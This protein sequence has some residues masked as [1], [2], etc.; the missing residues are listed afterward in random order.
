MRGLTERQSKV[1]TQTSII[2]A[3]RA[4]IGIRDTTGPKTMQSTIRKT[5][6]RKVESRVRAPEVFTLTIVWPIIAQPPIPPNRPV[7]MLA[8]PWPRDSRVLF[9]RV[10][11]I[12]S[13]SWAVIS[14]SI[15]PTRAKA[16][17][18]GAIRVRVAAVN[19]TSGR[20]GSGS[21]AG[22]LPLSPTV[23]TARWAPA[24][25]AVSATIDTSGAGTTVVN[26]GSSA[27]SARPP[28]SSG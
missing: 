25:T 7:T 22:S 8:T 14:D 3:T 17:A 2:T 19:G 5:P 13:T 9:E 21:P 20:P 24:V 28:T 18:Y 23:G 27:V 1:V 16:S 6:D 11:V 4:A 26:R 15:S 12:S 10:P